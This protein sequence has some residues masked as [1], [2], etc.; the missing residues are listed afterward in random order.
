MRMIINYRGIRI[1]K[2]NA[3]FFLGDNLRPLRNY[4]SLA[5]VIDFI[6]RCVPL[7]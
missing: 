3:E 4:T 2:I 5:E 6:D 1:T 7:N